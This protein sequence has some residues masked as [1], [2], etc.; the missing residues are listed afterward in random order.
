MITVNDPLRTLKVI[1]D[2]KVVLLLEFVLNE[3]QTDVSVQMCAAVKEALVAEDGHVSSIVPLLILL[4][5]MVTRNKQCSGH[6]IDQRI[7]FSCST[8]DKLYDSLIPR[9]IKN[10]GT[11]R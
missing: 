3:P 7:L 11:D 10:N 6:Q 4:C 9:S 8:E 1:G 2:F 5:K